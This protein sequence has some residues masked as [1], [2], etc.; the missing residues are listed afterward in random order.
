MP[1]YS[2]LLSTTTV[3]VRSLILLECST[4]RLHGLRRPRTNSVIQLTV[5]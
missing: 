4:Q 2:M 3:L 5:A 1:I